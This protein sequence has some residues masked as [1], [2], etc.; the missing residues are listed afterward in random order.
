MY[1]PAIEDYSVPDMQ[2]D[3]WYWYEEEDNL[4][5]TETQQPIR[6]ANK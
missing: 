4:A 3:L 5:Y 1:F 2:A 6:S